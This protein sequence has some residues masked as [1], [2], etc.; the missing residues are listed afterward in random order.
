VIAQMLEA[1][2][3]DGEGAQS[4]WELGNP[5]EIP[6]EGLATLPGCDDVAD[7]VTDGVLPWPDLFSRVADE[8]AERHGLDEAHLRRITELNRG[9][10]RHNP[11]AQARN[12]VM[13]DGAL[14][15]DAHRNPVVAGMLRASDCG[16]ITDGA[17]AIVL[18]SSRF[19][20]R[21]RQQRPARSLSRIVG[22][23]HRSAPLS[24]AAKLR[25][26]DASG[27]MFP[28]LR[29]AILDAYDRAVLHR[30][31]LPQHLLDLRTRIGRVHLTHLVGE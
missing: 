27:Y 19:A 15:T 3:P 6:A 2:Y 31:M 13:D 7:E 26:R 28:A 12:W 29:R 4:T 1:P 24:L 8:V 22:W 30:R 25:T 20:E 10:A 16:L 17:C 9:H 5:E 11:N 23:G 14:G 18:A 21:W